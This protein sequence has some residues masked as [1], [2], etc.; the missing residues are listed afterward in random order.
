MVGLSAVQSGVTTSDLEHTVQIAW[1]SS[2]HYRKLGSERRN[3]F[4]QKSWKQIDLEKS[5]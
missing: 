1:T 5:G 3:L 4:N 2:L